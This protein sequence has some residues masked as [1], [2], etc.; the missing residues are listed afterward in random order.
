VQQPKDLT[1]QK[2]AFTKLSKQKLNFAPFGKV[3]STVTSANKTT[4]LAREASFAGARKPTVA[5]LRVVSIL[6]INV[7]SSDSRG[8]SKLDTTEHLGMKNEKVTHGAG[9]CKRICRLCKRP[10]AD[11]LRDCGYGLRC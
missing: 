10:V 9:L 8:F 1:S 4:V 5:K 7:P 6:E 2:S 11:D 3:T